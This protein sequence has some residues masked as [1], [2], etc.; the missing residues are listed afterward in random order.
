MSV[1]YLAVLLLFVVL[2]HQI[3]GCATN[4]RVKI[5]E[6]EEEAEQL[7]SAG[8]YDSAFEKYLATAMRGK[9]ISQ[10]NVSAMY[11]HGIGVDRDLIQAYA[12]ASVAAEFGV[13]DMGALSNLMRLKQQL[14]EENLATATQLAFEYARLY[15]STALASALNMITSSNMTIPDLADK[16]YRRGKY[17]QA[18]RFYS[19]LAE[20]G[21][22][23]SQY[24]L[25]VMYRDSEG[26]NRDLAQSYAWASLSAELGYPVMVEHFNHLVESMTDGE[27]ENGKIYLKEI[28]RKSSLLALAKLRIRNLRGSLLQ[29]AKTKTPGPC[30][31]LVQAVCLDDPECTGDESRYNNAQSQSITART[32]N[33]Y[34]EIKQLCMG[35]G[36]CVY[37]RFDHSAGVKPGVNIYERYRS[38]LAGVNQFIDHYLETYGNVILG[39]FELIEDESENDTSQFENDR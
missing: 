4:T 36:V 14:N 35:D 1:K 20:A 3:A 8:Q 26:V 15:S 19:K 31:E 13:Y 29:C 9:K 23:F 16:Y 2:L 7:F 17:R 34:G 21:D 18:L 37:G 38:E 12:W 5:A 28:Y 10:Y 32:I 11:E 24:R 30:P 39:E 27:I 33:T 6:Y 22:K 25:S